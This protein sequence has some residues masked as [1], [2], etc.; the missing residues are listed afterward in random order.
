LIAQHLRDQPLSLS[1]IGTGFG[2][3]GTLSLKQALERLGIGRCYHM[4]EVIE[5]PSHIPLW[6]DAADGKP[7]DWDALFDGFSATVD[8][9]ST[10]FWRELTAAYPNAKVIH[11]V[12][13]P[14]RWYE[15]AAS[16]IFQHMDAPPPEDSLLASLVTMARKVVYDGVFDGRIDDRDHAVE[17]FKRHTED[18]KREID[19]D[20][21]LV[22]EVAQGWKPLCEFLSLPVPDEP[23]PRANEREEFQKMF[24]DDVK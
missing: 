15:S 16:T 19:A 6:S 4:M 8:N 9:P 2:R 17:I 12:R 23:F 21:L 11:T 24:I 20:R 3:T 7:V 1:I 5:N 18:V 13:D 10:V 14:E 22:F